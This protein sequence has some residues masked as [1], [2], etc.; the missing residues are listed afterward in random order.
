MESPNKTGI[1][2]IIWNVALLFCL[3]CLSPGTCHLGSRMKENA[4]NNALIKIH[5]N[6]R[7]QVTNKS[8]AEKDFIIFIHQQFCINTGNL[9]FL[10]SKINKIALI[11]AFLFM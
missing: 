10:G 1:L 5:S 11:V 6:I 4:Q 9:L 8:L 7:L 2:G 3:H